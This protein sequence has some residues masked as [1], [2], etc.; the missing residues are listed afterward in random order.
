MCDHIKSP[1]INPYETS[2]G[3]GGGVITEKSYMTLNI[4]F[5]YFGA[6]FFYTDSFTR[7]TELLC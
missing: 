3:G 1:Q 2:H 7:I 5:I 4:I 6:L